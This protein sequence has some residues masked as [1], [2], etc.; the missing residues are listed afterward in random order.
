MYI[1][2]LQ[3]DDSIG[4]EYVRSAQLADGTWV[5][6]RRVDAKQWKTAQGAARWLAA[7]PELSA[8]ATTEAA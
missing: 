1:I 6:R 7:H 8:I 5:T 3:F 2:K 4:I